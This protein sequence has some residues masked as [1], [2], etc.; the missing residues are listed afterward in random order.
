MPDSCSLVTQ[1]FLLASDRHKPVRRVLCKFYLGLL[2]REINRKRS[3]FL[4]FALFSVDRVGVS[5]FPHGEMVRPT[6]VLAYLNASE[7]PKW[8]YLRDHINLAW[9]DY[10]FHWS[11]I[12]V[13]TPVMYSE[14]LQCANVR[15]GNNELLL[16]LSRIL[17]TFILAIAYFVKLKAILLRYGWWAGRILR[18]FLQLYTSS[19]SA[20]VSSTH[21][22]FLKYF[23]K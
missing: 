8:I 18:Q 4:K 2:N 22:Y 10:H 23:L 6:R 1:K 21:L 19:S 3:F 20:C 9:A 12:I 7:W 5:S 13:I 15:L 17:L 16:M 11:A 14:L